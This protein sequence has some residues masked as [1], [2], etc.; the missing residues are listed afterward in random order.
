MMMMM[1]SKICNYTN[2]SVRRTSDKWIIGDG[3]IKFLDDDILEIKRKQYKGTQGLYELMFKKKPNRE[4]YTSQD[5]NIYKL[6]I[7]KTNAY[8]R[9][10]MGNRQVNGNGGF[11]YKHIIKPLLERTDLKSGEGL[12]G[13]SM[14]QKD[15]ISCND[16][17]KLTDRLGLLW[18]SEAAGNNNHKSEIAFI[19][20]QLRRQKIIA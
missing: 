11:K 14:I 15:Y 12:V 8:K 3:E 20:S 13:F 18:A 5:L 10:Y 2:P 4:I 19:L 17:N 9:N 1:M 16:P 6:I 7:D